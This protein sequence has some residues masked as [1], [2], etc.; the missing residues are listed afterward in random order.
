[1]RSSLFSFTGLS[2][3]QCCTKKTGSILGGIVQIER[4]FL[5][6]ESLACKDDRSPG[7]RQVF[8][9]VPFLWYFLGC[10][11]I[12]MVYRWPTRYGGLLCGYRRDLESE[13]LTFFVSRST[14]GFLRSAMNWDRCCLRLLPAT[15]FNRLLD[16]L[17]ELSYC[18]RFI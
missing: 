13:K 5:S 17:H 9:D 8:S 12:P 11:G 3:L 10:E 4:T 18:L 15:L 6:A 14:S 16:V 7:T 1:M 2:T